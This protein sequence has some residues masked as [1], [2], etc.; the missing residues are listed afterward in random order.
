MI[1]MPDGRIS[2]YLTGVNYDP[3]TV[4]MSLV[5]ASDGKIGTKMDQLFLTCFQYD[6]KQGKYAVFAMGVMRLGGILTVLV[7]SM[8]LLRL[9][10][11][12]RHHRRDLL[13]T[14]PVSSGAQG[15]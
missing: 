14:A 7:V 13:M 15:A 3:K 4:R 12:E 11:R 2:R 8:V 10:L 1:C 5:E 9:F 6:G